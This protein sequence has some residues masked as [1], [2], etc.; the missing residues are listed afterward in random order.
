MIQITFQY[1]DT[2][3][4]R[5]FS[6]NSITIGRPDPRGMPDLDLHPDMTVSRR[7][8]RLSVEAGTVSLEDLNSKYG[9]LVNGRKIRHRV[10]ISSEDRIRIGETTL[11]LSLQEQ[12]PELCLTDTLPREELGSNINIERQLDIHNSGPVVANTSSKEHK[13][14]LELLFNLPLVFAAQNSLDDL[15]EMIAQQMLDIIPGALHSTLLLMDPLT[16][17]LVLKAYLPTSG[18]SVSRTLARRAMSDGCGFIWRKGD[19]DLS[20]TMRGAQT[21]MYAPLLWNGVPVGVIAVDSPTHDAAFSEENLRLMMAV[22]HY[23]S[24]AVANYQLQ[25]DLQTNARLLETLLCSFSP[26]IRNILLERA[27]RGHL[28]PGGEKSE[29]TI[30]FGDIRGFT[31]KCARMDAVDVSEMLNDYFADLVDAIF[32]FDGTIDKFVG[33]A[34]VAIFGSPEVDLQ[35]HEHA[36]RAGLAMQDAAKMVTQRRTARHKEVCEIGI[37]IHC[38]VVLHGFI[39]AADRLDFTVI[40]DAV[41]RA[42]RLSDGAKGGDVL[43]SPEVFRRVFNTVKTEQ[44]S[45]TTKH[46]EILEAHRVKSLFE[47]H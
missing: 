14:R 15:L 29:V 36:V 24:M 23:A 39:G 6:Q 47:T 25:Q 28:S 3:S 34:V 41:N 32:R 44:V 13:R 21:G 22:G 40:G 2:E 12:A 4:V 18:H 38:G 33:D 26:K 11:T 20:E 31:T 17:Q 16:K 9:V 43:I 30:L 5:K 1:K 37:G 19:G 8:A 42:S 46:G 35:Q 7:H 10:A 45:V 27:K